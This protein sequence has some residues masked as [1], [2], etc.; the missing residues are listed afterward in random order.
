MDVQL[1][2]G[3]VFTESLP[4]NGYTRHNIFQEFDQLTINIY[5]CKTLS[6]YVYIY[7]Y[8][9][10]L[11]VLKWQD[12]QQRTL[13]ACSWVTINDTIWYTYLETLDDGRK[14]ETCSVLMFQYT[15]IW[16]T[17]LCWWMYCINVSFMSCIRNKNNQRVK[18]TKRLVNR[19]VVSKGLYF[20]FSNLTSVDLKYS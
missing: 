8:L 7:A 17:K 11:C 14:T 15:P 6:T 3:N 16:K 4:R 12:Q 5:V 1:L 19:I 13:C 20:F 2:R 9:Y 10:A 18:K